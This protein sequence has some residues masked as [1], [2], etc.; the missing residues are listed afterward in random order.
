MKYKRYKKRESHYWITHAQFKESFSEVIACMD[1]ESGYH[2]QKSLE[3]KTVPSVAC[4]ITAKRN[5]SFCLTFTQPDKVCCS[6][7]YEY[8]ALRIFVVR[9]QRAEDGQERTEI[10]KTA[11]F[12]PSRHSQLE[13]R[14]D[15]G[16]YLVLADV[17]CQQSEF[18]RV[19]V[20][21]GL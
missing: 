4:K 18:G 16:E 3:Y 14:L 8:A 11:F 21:F 9:Q 12:G 1:R 10:V 19:F 20:S 7:E 17:D 6:K 13:M 5:T 15:P 2:I